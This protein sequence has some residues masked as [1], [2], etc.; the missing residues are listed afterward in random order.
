M[1]R[2]RRSS[3]Q[4]HYYDYD[5][6]G[7][8]PRRRRIRHRGGLLTPFRRALTTALT[9]LFIAVGAVVF[10]CLVLLIAFNFAVFLAVLWYALLVT[11]GLA[12]FGVL[13]VVVRIISGISQRLS[14]ASTARAKARQEHIRVQQSS[15]RVQM[16]QVRLARQEE[17][18]YE[19]QQQR[20]ALPQ[21]RER[22][23]VRAQEEDDGQESLVRVL[24]IQRQPEPEGIPGMPAKNQIFQ[25]RDYKKLLKAGELI[26]GIRQDGSARIGTWQDFKITLILGSSSSGKSTTVLEKCLSHVRQGGLLVICDPGGFKPDSLTQRLGPL[27]QALLPGTIVA[28]EHKDIMQ[29]VE[30]FRVELERRR[31]GAD[32]TIPLLLVIDELNGLLMDKEI[33]KDLTELIEKFA[34]QA[35]GYHMSMILCAQRASGL[36]AIRNSVISFVC[37][38]CPEMEASKIL[39]AR[40][41]RLAPQLGVGQTFVSDANGSIEPLQQLYITAQ[42]IAASVGSRRWPQ[43]TPPVSPARAGPIASQ[44]AP[45]PPLSASMPP[46]SGPLHRTKL[47]QAPP[48]AATPQ[49]RKHASRMTGAIWGEETQVNPPDPAS[50]PAAPRLSPTTDPLDGRVSRLPVEAPTQMPRQD[51]FEM[52]ALR[53]GKKKK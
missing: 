12:L 17:L 33:K 43:S 22:P 53:R 52:L 19:Q 7:Y 47:V 6:S 44:P 16:Q 15:V 9:R 35:R 21:Q 32:M 1:A 3:P 40:Y 2:R 37:H 42:D 41:A 13:Y 10:F 45:A 51:T 31:R 39:P 36:A 8:H 18:W 11:G 5:D 23:G 48:D 14:A 30:H 27:R 26:I 25:Y 49:V 38:K 34:Q 46:R 28:L 20:K 29:N 24:P 4:A 50:Q